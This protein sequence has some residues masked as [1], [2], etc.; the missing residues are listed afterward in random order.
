MLLFGGEALRMKLNSLGVNQT[1]QLIPNS[2]RR[3]LLALKLD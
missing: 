1:A 3:F 2:E